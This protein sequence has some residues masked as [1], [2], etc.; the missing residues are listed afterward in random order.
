M[1]L[2][3]LPVVRLLILPEENAEILAQLPLDEFFLPYA[4]Q[5]TVIKMDELFTSIGA[6]RDKKTGSTSSHS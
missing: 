6:K 3:V 2:D 4:P 5:M 1:F